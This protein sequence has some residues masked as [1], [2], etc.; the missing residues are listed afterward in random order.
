MT[1]D[2]REFDRAYRPCVGIMTINRDGLAWIGRRVGMEGIPGTTGTTGWQMPQ[3]GIDAG[4]DPRTAAFRELTEETGMHSVE[5]VAETAGWHTYDLPP[6]LAKKA[7]KGRWRGQRQ[8]WFLLRFL[9]PDS[10]ID[11]SAKPGHKQEF[12]A[13]RWAPIDEV[14]GLIVPFKRPVYAAVI[15]EFRPAVRPS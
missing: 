9:G 1:S 14:E 12:D 13:W 4:E 2:P 5:I 8:K 7:W 3:G 10:E 11:I 15:A 6:D